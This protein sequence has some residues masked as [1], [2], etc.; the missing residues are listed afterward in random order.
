MLKGFLD[1][2]IGVNIAGYFIGV[3]FNCCGD[4]SVATW[5]DFG[6]QASKDLWV[7]VWIGGFD[8]LDWIFLYIDLLGKCGRRSTG[9]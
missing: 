3:G 7:D 1:V 4:L 2:L 9:T 8:H 5:K 6:I